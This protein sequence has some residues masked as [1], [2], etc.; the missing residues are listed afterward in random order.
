MADASRSKAEVAATNNLRK[1]YDALLSDASDSDACAAEASSPQRARPQSARSPVSHTLRNS[2][3]HHHHH[4]AR[5]ISG[6]AS[7]ANIA[8][9][10]VRS[11]RRQRQQQLAHEQALNP[12]NA[13]KSPCKLNYTR[14]GD[15]SLSSVSDTSAFAH[16]ISLAATTAALESD[17]IELQREVRANELRCTELQQQHARLST[18]A[19]DLDPKLQC[20]ED[21]LGSRD[22]RRYLHDLYCET[23]AFR[24]HFAL[25]GRRFQRFQQRVWETHD[26]RATKQTCLDILNRAVA[27][28]SA[29]EQRTRSSTSDGANGDAVVLLSQY[30]VLFQHCLDAHDPDRIV[31]TDLLAVL[32]ALPAGR[33]TLL[34]HL[35]EQIADARRGE[36]A[37]PPP[38]VVRP[39]KLLAL[40]KQSLA[41]SLCSKAEFDEV[42]AWLASPQGDSDSSNAA[43]VAL[44][45][46]L[47]FHIAK[48]DAFG[49]ED[50]E[51]V[52]YL[53]RM[54]RL[55]AS[56][57]HIVDGSRSDVVT[58]NMVVVS[59]LAVASVLQSYETRC[60]LAASSE[61]KR[62]LIAKIQHALAHHT[63]KVEALSARVAALQV[64]QLN[65]PAVWQCVQRSD[66]LTAQCA[67]S[68]AL[69]RV[70]VLSSQSLEAIP[71]FVICLQQ[72]QVLDLSDNLIAAIPPE[73]AQL[74]RLERLALTANRLTDK[75]FHGLDAHFAR[76]SALCELQIGGNRL[77]VL[78]RAITALPSL[79]TL[80]LSANQLRSLPSA[81]VAKWSDRCRLVALDLHNNT[82]ASLPDEIAAMSSTLRHLLL[83]DNKL[84]ALPAA[85]AHMPLIEQLTLSHN[86]LGG[87]FHEYPVM[88]AQR[89]VL[90]DHNQLRTFPALT[91]GVKMYLEGTPSAL[92]SIRA[93]WNS[94]RSIPASI[95]ASLLLPACEELD[96]QHNSLQELPAELF[97]AL[98]ALRVCRL[99]ANALTALP[100]SITTCRHLRVLDVQQNRITALSPE[101][102]HLESLTAL[103]A[104]ENRLTSVPS[105]WHAFA[106]YWSDDSDSA[107]PR[108][109]LQTLSLKKNPI[110]NKVLKTLVDG[111]SVELSSAALATTKPSDESVCEFAIKKIIDALL[112]TVDVL[113]LETEG[114]E[115]DTDSEHRATTRWKGVT[116]NVNKYLELKLQAMHARERRR[117][118]HQPHDALPSLNVSE[119]A[120]RHLIKSLPSTCSEQELASLVAQFRAA[121]IS[122]SGVAESLP[123]DMATLVSGHAFLLAIDQFGQRRTLSSAPARTNSSFAMAKPG[124]PVANI[125][126][127]LA[128]VH[129][130][131]QQQRASPVKRDPKTARDFV[132][133][134]RDAVEKQSSVRTA[135]SATTKRSAARDPQQQQVDERE[136]RATQQFLQR[137]LDP[138]HEVLV[139]R[140]QQRI[141]ILE[142]Q[143]LDQKLLQLSQQQQ[144]TSSS[145]KA[146]AAVAPA[147]SVLDDD[148]VSDDSNDNSNNSSSD[149]VASTRHHPSTAQL[150][151]SAVVVCVK[152]VKGQ[153]HL[154]AMEQWRRRGALSFAVSI[155]ARISDVKQRIERET[156]IPIAHQVLIAPRS[157]SHSSAPSVRVRND[158]AVREYLEVLSSAGKMRWTIALLVSETLDGAVSRPAAAV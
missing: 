135:R 31:L 64:L 139:K 4:L 84:T 133:K 106:S 115:S 34:R 19:S 51:F 11:L 143:L 148:D 144:R 57:V 91:H 97:T 41:Q 131:Q 17:L 63:S 154:P 110:A 25:Y 116:R 150:D 136:A 15:V 30:P 32:S 70:L 83:H 49:A 10:A 54:W 86:A 107:S 100:L 37:K 137:H 122:S 105:E 69:L 22:F 128:V 112:H 124:D 149:D 40:A 12:H 43:G 104:S 29:S 26:K 121:A 101:L 103:Y 108:R 76:L 94:L 13:S 138:E 23:A 145:A 60:Q 36:G 156:H 85:V 77:A 141:A 9:D 88:P 62:E 3:N 48:S 81:V 28:T 71:R 158:A 80:N 72:L 39:H 117:G 47:A 157:G 95:F 38:D 21:V 56:P 119:R 111:G 6:A 98:P 87:A 152:C 146:S 67:S 109:A 8:V 74:E 65:S 1:L 102:A 2:S 127:Y 114:V 96:L 99:S 50:A 93:S 35:F 113:A 140:Q 66:R 16:W 147:H 120:F 82:L 125:L 20:L 73:V 153:E 89:H 27:S 18:D 75:S 53:M 90:L 52:T 7:S 33:E 5:G 126:H 44:H 142:Q 42:V 151:D 46:F 130:Q 92:A 68:L 55:Q 79:A 78:P 24:R 58:A 118:A 123:K 59:D 134:N 14:Q 61:R 155:D 45:S 129:S 132:K